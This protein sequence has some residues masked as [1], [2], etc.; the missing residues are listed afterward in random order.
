MVGINAAKRFKS[1]TLCNTAAR[2]GTIEGWNTRIARIKE[3]GIAPVAN[4]VVSRWFT[5]DFRQARAGT[6]VEAARQML[7]T[8]RRKATPLRCAAIA[9]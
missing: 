9:G 5:E 3:G 1:L 7:L 6:W 2:I 4:G 8:R